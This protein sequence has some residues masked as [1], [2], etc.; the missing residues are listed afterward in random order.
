MMRP[1]NTITWRIRD[2]SIILPIFCIALAALYL[3]LVCEKNFFLF[4]LLLK[5]HSY[6]NG[7]SWN[8]RLLQNSQFTAKCH[9]ET[10]SSLDVSGW[11]LTIYILPEKRPLAI[12]PDIKWNSYVHLWVVDVLTFLSG[13]R[14][15]LGLTV[16]GGL[17][18]WLQLYSLSTM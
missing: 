5:V 15:D 4:Y 18:I 1:P 10:S 14:T 8:Y 6:K 13:P 16:D 9:L 11:H 3:H 7:R 2:I 12:K 17:I